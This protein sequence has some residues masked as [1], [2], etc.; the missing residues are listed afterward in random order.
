[1]LLELYAQGIFPMAESEYMQEVHFFRPQVRALLPIAGLH[2]PRSLKKVIR[3]GDFTVTYDQAFEAVIANCATPGDNRP[4]TWIN[5]PIRE[6]FI[7]LHNQGHAHSIETWRYG[8]LVGGLYGLSVGAAFCG[9]S[10]FSSTSNASK[11]ALVHLCARLW[12]AGYH[13]LDTQ[14]TNTHLE[15]FGVYEV[16]N[17]D[18]LSQLQDALCIEPDFDLAED[19][20]GEDEQALVQVFLSKDSEDVTAPANAR[21]R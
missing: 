14:F 15:Q 11:V 10:M 21:V 4:S 16:S 1:M 19:E 17:Q 20:L 3:R 5:R 7:T 9:E 8:E 12:G 18:Y 2:V 6:A 13:L